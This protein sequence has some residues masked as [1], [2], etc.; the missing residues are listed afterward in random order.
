MKMHGPLEVTSWQKD[1]V[2][3]IG[4]KKKNGYS[5]LFGW[6]AMD[7]DYIFQGP[8]GAHLRKSGDLKTIN[9][10]ENE[11]VQRADK[12]VSQLSS[13]VEV[14]DR[15]LNELEWEYN[16]IIESLDKMV[17]ENEKLKLSHEKR[18]IQYLA[19]VYIVF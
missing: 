6:V 5:G 1:M 18:K 12:L 7:E 11:R 14:K 10:F 16:G 15:H 3:Q 2:K 13:Q 19:L 9:E 17:R 8:I 4:R